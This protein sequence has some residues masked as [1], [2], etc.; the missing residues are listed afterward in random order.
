MRTSSTLLISIF[1][2]S[3]LFAQFPLDTVWH[4]IP[5]DTLA[6]PSYLQSTYDSVYNIKITRISD[7]VSYGFPDG[8]GE[9]LPP[10]AKVQAWNA[11]MTKIVIGFTNVLNANDYT[12]YKNITYP[13]GY[14]NDSRWSNVD[15]NIRYFCYNDKFLKINIETDQIDTLHIFPGYNTTIGPWEG[16]ISAD[17]KYVVITNDAS[18]KASLYDI[19]LDILVSSKTFPVNSFDWITITPSNDYIAVSNNN[20]GKV[21]LY[22]LNFNYLKDLSD[23]QQHADFAIDANGNE[24]LVQVIPLSMTRLDNGQ[25]TDLISSALVCGN[26]SFNPSIAGHISGRNFGLPGWALASTQISSECTNGLGYY[27]RTE[28]FAIKLDGSGTIRHYG[29]AH[30]SCTSYDTYSK[31]SFSPDGTK[32]IFSSDWNIY[33]NGSNTALAYIA[34]SCEGGNCSLLPVE[35][36]RFEGKV[37]NRKVKLNWLTAS[38]TNSLAYEIQRSKNSSSWK[39]IGSVATKGTS[40]EHNNYEFIDKN[41]L[42]ILSYYRLKQIDIDGKFDYSKIINVN[43]RNEGK[44]EIYPNPTNGKLEIVG[45]EIIEIKIRDSFGRIIKEQATSSQSI[46]ISEFPTGIYFISVKTKEGVFTKRIVKQ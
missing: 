35:L 27:Y 42:D 8:S 39:T 29:F 5:P 46:S 1:L 12:L 7:A 13:G 16:N 21:E 33:E 25:V 34:E 2:M 45:V 41:P 26:F 24:V 20:T 6:Q 38:E 40:S 18:D 9:L 31:A 37:I 23:N 14:F 17:D 43:F 36:V 3:N 28:M 10:Y 32:V 30:T 19:K 44:I 11:D 4:P 15:P 22:D